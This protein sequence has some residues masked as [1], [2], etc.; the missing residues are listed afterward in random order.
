MRHA[1]GF[2]HLTTR[3]Q[4]VEPTGTAP[5]SPDVANG[6]DAQVVTLAGN[7]ADSLDRDTAHAMLEE[8]TRAATRLGDDGND[9]WTGF[10][11]TNVLLHRVNIALTLGDAGTLPIRLASADTVIFLDLPAKDMPVGHRRTPVALPRRPI[12]RRRR[13]RPDPLGLCPLHP[14]LPALPNA[15]PP[16]SGEELLTEFLSLSQRPTHG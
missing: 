15:V 7:A 2:L 6:H 16:A 9:R 5:T 1:A 10:G 3:A 4:E 8:A 11:A 14:R 12:P 13:L